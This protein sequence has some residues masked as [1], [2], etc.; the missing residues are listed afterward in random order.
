VHQITAYV[1]ADDGERFRAYAASFGLDASALATLLLIRELRV[2]H[3]ARLAAADLEARGQAYEKITAHQSDG[4]VKARWVTHARASGLSV[5]RAAAIV[6]RA[7]LRDLWLQRA[8]NE[9]DSD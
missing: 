6:F 3:L 1:S 4:T 5:S 8:V 2:D 7:E 9:F